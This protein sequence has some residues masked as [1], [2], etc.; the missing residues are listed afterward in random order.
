MNCSCM[1]WFSKS[2]FSHLPFMVKFLKS[3]KMGVNWRRNHLGLHFPGR[4]FQGFGRRREKFKKYRWKNMKRKPFPVNFQF[5]C[6]FS[7]NLEICK[8]RIPGVLTGPGSEEDISLTYFLC[9]KSR[10]LCF[11]FSLGVFPKSSWPLSIGC[12]GRQ[13]QHL[14][15]CLSDKDEVCLIKS[16]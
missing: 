10:R 11:Q 14:Y 12:P 2:V 1:I 5:S 6:L 9:R 4:G 15:T 13:F 3:F 8:F 7:W 16:V